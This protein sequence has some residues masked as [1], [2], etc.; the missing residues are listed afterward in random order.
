[1]SDEDKSE[2]KKILSKLKIEKW[3]TNTLR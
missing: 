2:M 3:K 1:L